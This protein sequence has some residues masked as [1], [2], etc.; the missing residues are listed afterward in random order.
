LVAGLTLGKQILQDFT[1]ESCKPQTVACAVRNVRVAYAIT[2]RRICRLL[3]Q[4]RG[5]QR[6]ARI[7]RS[8]DVNA[9]SIA[10]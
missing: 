3:V 7:L 10:H 9:G 4:W 1:G 8:D 5:T 2:D 6:Y